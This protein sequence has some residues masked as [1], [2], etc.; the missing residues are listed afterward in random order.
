MLLR[1]VSFM[2][3]SECASAENPSPPYC[4]GMI[5]PMKPLSRMNCHACGG[6]SS[7]S[8]ETSQ[9][10]TIAHNS[11]TGPSRK[12]RSSADSFGIG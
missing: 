11:S 12:A 3:T 4:L 7:S 9:S 6:R 8:C 2:I 10:F 1:V 5:M